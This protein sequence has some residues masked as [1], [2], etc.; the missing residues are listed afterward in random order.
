[1]LSAGPTKHDLEYWQCPTCGYM[2]T[3]DMIF[4]LK[5]DLPCPR[6]GFHK[7]PEFKYYE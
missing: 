1:M 5:I 2:I 7:Y 3:H 6:C 4:L